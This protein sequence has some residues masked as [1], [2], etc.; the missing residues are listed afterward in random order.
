GHCLP[1]DSV[2]VA[3]QAR[4]QL[5]RPFKIAELAADI[6]E[7]RP[8]YVVNRAVS[9]LGDRG[10][11]ANG[12]SVLVMGLAYKPEVGDLRESPAVTIVD[13]LVDRGV[14]VTVVDP[15][16]EGWTQTPTL[17]I[18]DLPGAARTFD[19]VIVATNHAIFDYEKI[20][21]ESQQVLDCR[22]SMR[23]SEVVVA[24]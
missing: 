15:L 19:L 12:A 7:S 11:A 2:Y 6:N 22:N 16:V 8:T 1:I 24:L 21:A 10:I 5:G 9:L 14:A 3:W 18:E 13:G 20:A 17:N 4:K 23:P